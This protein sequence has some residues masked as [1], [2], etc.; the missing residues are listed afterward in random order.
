MPR[1]DQRT[2]LSVLT[3]RRLLELAESFGID[4]SSRWPK[5]ELVGAVAS[6]RRAPLRQWLTRLRRDELKAICRT[7]GIDDSG[8]EKTVIAERILRHGLAG[9]LASR[10]NLA[11]GT[12]STTLTRVDLA[13]SVAAATGL[14]KKDAEEIVEEVFETLIESLRQGSKIELRGFGSFRLRERR[15]RIGRNPSTGARVEVP[16]KRVCYF[17]PGRELRNFLS[18]EDR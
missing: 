16:A 2:A 13:E 10:R 1:I 15:S 4:T 9:G 3:R 7:A 6:S 11:P 8:R 14:F 12:P 5:G 17:K 18:R